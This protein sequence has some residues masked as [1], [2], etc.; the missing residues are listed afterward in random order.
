MTA[1]LP[2]FISSCQTFKVDAIDD[3]EELEYTED[4]FNVL[5]FSAQ[6]KKFFE[7]M[8]CGIVLH[9]RSLTATC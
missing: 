4:A 2:S 6:V 8:N 7:T 5:G 1:I 9:R 3:N